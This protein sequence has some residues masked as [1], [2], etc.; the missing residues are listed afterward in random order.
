MSATEAMLEGCENV[1]GVQMF[2]D[3]AADNMLK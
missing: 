3:V 1:I 2:M